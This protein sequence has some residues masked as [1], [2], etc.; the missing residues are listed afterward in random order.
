MT[1]TVDG[2]RAGVERA[3]RA[4]RG[5]E[6]EA[7]VRQVNDDGASIG[8]LLKDSRDDERGKDGV[9]RL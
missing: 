8:S 3:T 2:A 4:E 7:W 6:H 1:F 5:V 9:V